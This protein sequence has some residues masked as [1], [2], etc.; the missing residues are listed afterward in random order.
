MDVRLS[1]IRRVFTCLT[2]QDNDEYS[3]IGTTTGDVFKIKIHR[4]EIK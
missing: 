4:D 3:Y 2:I 1:N